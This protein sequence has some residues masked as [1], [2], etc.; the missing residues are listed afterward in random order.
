MPRSFAP[1]TTLASTFSKAYS[2]V[3]TPMTS[4]P[5]SRYASY[6]PPT[7]GV[8]RWQLIQEYAQKGMST[9]LPGNDFRSIGAFPGVLS[10]FVMPLMS[11]AVPQ[12]SSSEPP[13]EQFDNLAFCSLTRP[14][15][16]SSRNCSSPPTCCCSAP[17]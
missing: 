15:R 5:S 7:C 11:G 1:L 12:L 16:L 3:C 9:T 6:Q 13:S 2:G 17:V 14:P 10:H 4:K 8:D